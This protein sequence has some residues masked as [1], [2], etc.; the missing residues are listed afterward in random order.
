M[1]SPSILIG[2][3]NWEIQRKSKNILAKSAMHYIPTIYNLLDLGSKWTSMEPTF[4]WRHFECASKQRQ[5]KDWFLQLVATC[6][7]NTK[8]WVNSQNLKVVIQKIDQH[9]YYV[10]FLNLVFIPLHRTEKDG[11]WVGFKRELSLKEM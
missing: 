6:D 3:F 10:C 4:G 9:F 1:L 11:V 5:G 8:F 7:Q 2:F